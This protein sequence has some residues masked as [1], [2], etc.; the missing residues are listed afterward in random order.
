MLAADG[1]SRTGRPSDPGVRRRCD[2]LRMSL[3]RALGSSLLLFAVAA[4]QADDGLG[5]P[6][7]DS[8]VAVLVGELG[9]GVP[10]EGE[11][12]SEIGLVFTEEAGETVRA[13][14][15][16]GRYEASLSP[17]TWSVRAVDGK[18]CTNG[19]ELTGGTRQSVDLVYPAACAGGAIRPYPG[20]PDSTPG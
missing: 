10:P 20:P 17:G 4:C 7:P 3:A 9:P 8:D 12:P 6:A 11:V 16:D 13:T 14:A 19:I 18:A 5:G 1:G 15:R 2:A